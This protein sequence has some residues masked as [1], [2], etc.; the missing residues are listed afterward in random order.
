MQHKFKTLGLSL[1][2]AAIMTPALAQDE[3]PKSFRINDIRSNGT[4]CPPGTVAL[5]ISDDQQAFTLTF[6]EFYAEVSPSIG[7]QQ[8]RKNCQVVFDTEQDSGWEYAIFAVTYRGFAALDP[9][10]QG[11]QKLRFGG[12]GKKAETTMNL[13]GPYDDNYINSQEVPV[14]NLKWSGCNSNKQKDFTI[15]AALNLQAPDT[16]SQGLFTVDTFDGEV[17]QEYEVLWRDCRG[18]KKSFAVCRL[19]VPSKDG[20]YQLISKH[21][22]KNPNQ[23]LAKAKSKMAKKCDKAKGRAPKCDANQAVCTVISL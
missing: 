20:N 15:D 12:V 21:P 3:A 23:A 8:Q 9:G 16:D 17:R 5:N 6:S 22:S 4:G 7:I 11:E 13:L 18:G 1:V 10:V 14:N 19:N 2:L